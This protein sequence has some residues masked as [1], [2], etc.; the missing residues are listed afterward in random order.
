MLRS[1]V[2]SVVSQIIL[3]LRYAVFPLETL[4]L[5]RIVLH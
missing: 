3:G 4:D 2:Q 1:V 5:S